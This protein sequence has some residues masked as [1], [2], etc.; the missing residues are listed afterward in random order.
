MKTYKYSTKD[1]AERVAKTLGC[2]GSHQHTEKGKKVFMPCKSHDIFT[3]KT[4]NSNAEVTELVDDDGTWQ[5]SSIPIIDPASKGTK[6][7]PTI[8]DK[9]VFMSKN[10][11]DPLLR[12]WYGYY[13]EGYVKEI[14]MSKAYGF[15][16]TQFMDAKETE[17]FFKKELKLEPENAKNRTLGQ[18]KKKGLDKKTPPKIKKKK[19][20][21]DREILKE[22]ENDEIYED[23]LLK[24][25]EK[26]NDGIVGDLIKKNVR[27]LKKMANDNNVSLQEL[28]YMLKDE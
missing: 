13:G 19:G 6:N 17:N 20:F 3:K 14:D 2:N 10:P 28:I 11:R 27:A 8:T 16:D 15:K 25:S 21:I 12:G 22:L 9:I 24:K 23:L 4:K 26:N 5:S 7:N 1:R 18:G